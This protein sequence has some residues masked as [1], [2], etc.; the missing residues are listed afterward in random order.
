MSE[1]L[2]VVAVD[3]V[4]E[5]VAK[6][7]EL[8][9]NVIQPHDVNRLDDRAL[10]VGGQLYRASEP[11]RPKLADDGAATLEAPDLLDECFAG[12]R[13]NRDR[14]SASLDNGHRSEST[15]A[16]L[17]LGAETEIVD[18]VVPQLEELLVDVRVAAGGVLRDDADRLKDGKLSLPV[19]LDWPPGAH[20]LESPYGATGSLHMAEFPVTGARG[21]ARGSRRRARGRAA[22]SVHRRGLF[23]V[24]VTGR[25]GRLSPRLAAHARAATRPRPG[26]LDV[27][28][29]APASQP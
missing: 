14:A 24:A 7:Q 19:E 6:L 17:R 13:R 16:R 8:R 5:V 28:R 23:A 21:G 12:V 18:E 1:R 20:S 2:L 27:D 15:T 3:L 9:I 10:F 26:P 29:A 25:S 4:D 11:T 22:R